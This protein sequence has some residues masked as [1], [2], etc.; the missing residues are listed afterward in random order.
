MLRK[1]SFWGWKI[2]HLLPGMSRLRWALCRHFFEFG[3]L[4]HISNILDHLL[5]FEAEVEQQ[6]LRQHLSTFFLTIFHMLNAIFCR[7]NVSS[8][9]INSIITDLNNSTFS[10]PCEQWFLQ[11]GR[12][13]RCSSLLEGYL[14]PDCCHKNAQLSY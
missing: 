4:F 2:P 10:L 11:A 1:K 12:Y 14:S 9:P 6:L 13:V 8:K 5:D 3:A 7:R